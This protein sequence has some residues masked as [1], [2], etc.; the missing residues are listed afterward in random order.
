MKR[1]NEDKDEDS[2]SSEEEEE[3]MEEKLKEEVHEKNHSDKNKENTSESENESDEDGDVDMSNKP[4]LENAQPDINPISLDNISDKHT[5]VL[6][7]FQQT[8]SLQGKID[9]S[10]LVS[11]NDDKEDKIASEY[12]HDLS[13]IPQPAIVRDITTEERKA[14]DEHNSKSMAWINTTK[15]YYDNTMVKQYDA[16][17]NQLRPKLL[18]NIIKYYSKET[19]PIQTILLD[20][21]LPILNFSLS[22]T[23]KHFTRRVGDIL[24]NASTGSGKTLGYCIPIIQALSSRKVNKLRSLII[25]PTKLLIN[26]VFDTLSKL[27]EGTSLIISISKLENSLKEEH[28]KFLKQEPDILIMTP[29]RLVDHL[30]L[31]S[32]NLKNLKMLVL[33]EADRLLNQSFQNWCSELMNKIKL[34]KNDKLPGNIIKFVFSATL[35]TNTEKLN[36]LQFYKP[37]LFIMDTV[38]LYNLPTTLQEFNINIPTA[39]S[40]YKPL[41]LLRLFANLKRSKILV[42]VKSN[43]ASLRLA[44]LLKM[45]N[46]K[47]LITETQDISSINSNNSRTDNKRLVNAF[48]STIENS[49]NKI[50]ITTDLISR[51][52]DINDITHVI[53]YDLPISSQ[54]YVHRCGR[55]ARAGSEGQAY[56][57]L[58]GKGEKQFWTQQIDNDISRDIG[59]YT[60]QLWGHPSGNATDDKDDDSVDSNASKKSTALSELL[61]ISKHEDE[62]YKECLQTLKQLSLVK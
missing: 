42:F 2:V 7:R 32:I 40:V 16:Y 12:I 48:S 34:E 61:S 37:K 55:T 54:Q 14:N 56:N 31:N 41:I 51:G 15:I 62:I 25:L 53:N 43:E 47:N 52:I 20:T 21:V 4:K 13:Q 35:T 8:L 18:Q 29:G 27:A 26:Q 45:M 49:I 59:G 36:K 57:M 1:K 44:S 50:L 5:S 38:K 23:K 22:I 17:S 3:N 46:D 30:Q 10:E 33:D 19:F 6:S 24:V 60:P 9:A 28:Q 58:V 11:E 39:K